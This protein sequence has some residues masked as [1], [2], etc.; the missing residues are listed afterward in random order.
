MSNSGMVVLPKARGDDAFRRARRHS[1]AVGVLKWLLP[2]LGILMAAAFFL[3]SYISSPMAVAIKAEGTA[4]SDGKL[5]MANPK[6]E[7]F[8]KDNRPYLMTAKRAV[9]DVADQ[10]IVAL[11]GIGAKLPIGDAGLATIDAAKGV[12]DR[13][14]NTLNLDSEITITTL[15]GMVAK[16]KSANLDIGAGGM[17]SKD[18]VDITFNGTRITSDSMSIAQSG[19]ILVFENR[20]RVLIDRHDDDAATR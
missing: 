1:R 20:V 17:T 11:E 10:G 5:V 8:T 15:D 9:Q 6:L 18:P 19:K 16:L 4:L 14:K 2:A 12:F 13:A 3:K 7:G